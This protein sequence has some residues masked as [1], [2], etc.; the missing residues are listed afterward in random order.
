MRMADQNGFW[1]AKAEIGWKMANSLL[2]FLAM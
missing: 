2:L 1:L